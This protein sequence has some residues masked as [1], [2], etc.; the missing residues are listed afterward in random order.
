L[1]YTF[2][3]SVNLIPE[4]CQIK[5]M[6]DMIKALPRRMKNTSSFNRNDAPKNA[7]GILV[8]TKGRK[9]FNLA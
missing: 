7:M 5:K 4:V 8:T 6:E 9:S 2:A 3:G 1:G